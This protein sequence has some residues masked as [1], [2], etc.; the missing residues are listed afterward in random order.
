MSEGRLDA[1]LLLRDRLSLGLADPD[2]QITVTVGLAQ[3]QHRLILRLLHAYADYPNLTHQRLPFA[4]QPSRKSLVLNG[5][6]R[7]APPT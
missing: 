7:L 6:E 4:I 2:R 1:L 5:R 3:K